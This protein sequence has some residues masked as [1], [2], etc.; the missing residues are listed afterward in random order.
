[1]ANI[2][3]LQEYIVQE[4]R[5]RVSSKLIPPRSYE[6]IV[7]DWDNRT[8]HVYELLRL[9]PPAVI[10][11]LIANT[12]P[13]D[14]IRDP[15]V[16]SF[17][18]AHMT[19][20]ETDPCAGIY[21]QWMAHAPGTLFDPGADTE[22]KFLNSNQVAQV[23]GLVE[24]Y[25]DNKPAS[26][27]VNNSIDRAFN[28]AWVSH[29]NRAKPIVDETLRKAQDWVGIVRKQYCTGIDS[30]K[31]NNAFLRVPMEVGW[32]Q[33]IPKRIKGH[34]TAA[35]TPPL[36]YLINATRRKLFPSSPFLKQQAFLFPVP[37]EEDTPLYKIAEILGSILCSSYHIYGGYNAH[38]AGGS[39]T[40]TRG[41][42]HQ[43]W[44]NSEEAYLSRLKWGYIG[45]GLR[46]VHDMLGQLAAARKLPA[47]RKAHAEE[48]AAYEERLGE[49]KLIRS[50][51]QR[52]QED[53]QN[54]KAEAAKR[55]TGA[56][57]DWLSLEN[58]KR[59]TRAIQRQR[60]WEYLTMDE[61]TGREY[62]EAL[63]DE[64][65]KFDGAL[66]DEVIKQYEEANARCR[67]KN[68]E[69]RERRRK[70]KEKEAEAP[71]S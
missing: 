19:I 24:G 44:Y 23:L 43:V 39:N 68:E 51:E 37:F 63:E 11:S 54:A 62:L 22:G 47:M 48:K 36:L 38:L 5:S 64:V 49:Y 18:E 17:F 14:A 7:E 55:T 13:F 71:S 33:D 32:A 21:V 46:H 56:A 16:K 57:A 42:D 20:N 15:E 41:E 50:K 28:P 66:V 35:G 40:P 61:G 26:H 34:N 12:L 4:A 58:G 59:I 65:L 60:V 52:L 3:G 27:D 8:H 29:R 53:Y 6:M 70:E 67:Q 9:L 25:L 31:S 2:L 69:D 1:M 30:N 45:S 10:R